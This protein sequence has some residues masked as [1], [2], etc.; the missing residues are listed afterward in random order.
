MRFFLFASLFFLSISC[1]KPAIKVLTY[2]IYHNENPYK[3]GQSNVSDISAL[4]KETHPDVVFLQEVDSMT[5]RS[6]GVFGKKVD[7]AAELAKLTQRISYFSKAIDFSGGGYGEALLLKQPNVVF[8]QKLPN[9]K[10]GEVR[11]MI[12]TEQNFG[13]KS[14]IMLGT[15]LCHQYS[16][17]RM[18]Q[19]EAIVAYYL[20]ND[21]PMILA[22]DFNF[23][24]DSPEYQYITGFFI[25]AATQF[26][27]PQNTFPADSPDSRIDYIFLS[28]KHPWKVDEIKVFSNQYSDHLP[29]FGK[30]RF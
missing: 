23:K 14:V 20:Q 18:A 9:P 26:Q 6:A 12:A 22:G 7:N 28:K 30:I 15:H 3:K 16:E 24:P 2:N 4:I 8:R 10:G 5:N 13:K 21:K 25:D 29:V 19:L 11:S 1:S 17:N 27:K